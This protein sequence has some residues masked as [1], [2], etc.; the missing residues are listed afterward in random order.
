LKIA[1]IAAKETKILNNNRVNEA[2][3][4]AVCGTQEIDDISR[5]EMKNYKKANLLEY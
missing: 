3:M 5:N 4:A 2:K 1:K